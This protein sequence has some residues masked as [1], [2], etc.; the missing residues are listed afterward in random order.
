MW[1]LAT[2]DNWNLLLQDRRFAEIVKDPNLKPNQIKYKPINPLYANPTS[3]TLLIGAVSETAKKYWYLG[4]RASKYLYV[5]PSTTSGF[6]R[7]VQVSDVKQIA[8]GRMNLVEF[9][10]YDVTPY[11]LQLDI[12]YWLEDIY[13]EVWEYD[14]YIEPGYQEVLD[15]L[16]S[17]ETKIDAIENYGI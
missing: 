8:L 11:T 1:D 3:N 6:I 4:A 16:D 2:R 13:I 12:P 9:K 14:G 17:I 15:R 7:G 10:D 5:S